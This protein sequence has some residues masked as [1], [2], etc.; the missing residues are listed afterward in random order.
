MKIRKIAPKRRDKKLM[1]F[2]TKNNILSAFRKKFKNQI[3]ESKEW[4][5]YLRK[6]MVMMMF[7]T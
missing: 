1:S 5:H 6:D 3:K 7:L 4:E 2:L